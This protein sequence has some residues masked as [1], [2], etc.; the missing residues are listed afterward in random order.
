[1]SSPFVCAKLIMFLTARNYIFIQFLKMISGIPYG[2]I[3]SHRIA[4]ETKG[5]QLYCNLSFVPKRWFLYELLGASLSYLHI[6]V[7]ELNLRGFPTGAWSC[8]PG[9]Y[10]KGNHISPL[11]F[12][13]PSITRCYLWNFGDYNNYGIICRR[14]TDQDLTYWNMGQHTRFK[15]ESILI[16]ICMLGILDWRRTNIQSRQQWTSYQRNNLS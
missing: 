9:I 4:I 2:H 6:K 15:I 11:S 1:M 12:S 10:V 14:R 3:H 5:F 13:L 8:D 7:W 16:R